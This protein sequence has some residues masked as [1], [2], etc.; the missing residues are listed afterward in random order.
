MGAGGEG[1]YLGDHAHYETLFLDLVGL[2]GVGVSEHLA[3][4]TVS[5]DLVHLIEKYGP[6]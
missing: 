6:E 1:S 3:C 5:V 4:G 2:D